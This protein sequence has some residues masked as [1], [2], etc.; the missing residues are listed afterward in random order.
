MLEGIRNG[1]TIVGTL[2]RLLVVLGRIEQNLA[3]LA[4]TQALILKMELLDRGSDLAELE[5]MGREAATPM[6][7][8]ALL[9]QSEE[10]FAEMDRQERFL[11]SRGR[12]VEDDSDLGTLQRSWLNAEG[13]EKQ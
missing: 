5:A 4:S 3:S 12:V 10:D 8:E 1:F 9:Q 6:D 7:D 11:K 2:R 13:G